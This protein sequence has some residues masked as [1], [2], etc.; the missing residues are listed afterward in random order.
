MPRVDLPVTAVT[1]SG[2]AQPA[3]TNAD[4]ANNHQLFNDGRTILEVRN[5]DGIAAQT[6]TFEIPGEIDLGI[7][8]PDRVITIP[9][10][11]VRLIGPFPLSYNQ[12]GTSLVHV[13]PGNAALR[14]RAYRVEF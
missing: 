7:A 8:V 11:A 6:I 10:T 5:S 1:R 14:F 13:N 12:P 9:A 2:V 4:T 3:E